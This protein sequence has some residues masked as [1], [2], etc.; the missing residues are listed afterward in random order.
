[1]HML[2]DILGGAFDFDRLNF[3]EKMIVR[4]SLGHKESVTRINS[5]SNQSFRYTDAGRN[6]YT[7]HE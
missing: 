4:K 5:Q 6:Y 2:K 1:M 7:L 3:V